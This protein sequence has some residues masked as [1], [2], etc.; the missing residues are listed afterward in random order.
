MINRATVGRPIYHQGA[1]SSSRTT[2][3]S[4]GPRQKA[5]VED[6]HYQRSLRLRGTGPETRDDDSTPKHFVK[7]VLSVKA[8]FVE[9][10]TDE[11]K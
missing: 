2:T 3:A 8:A 4:S 1:I 11:R 10:A 9:L 7:S 5:I 6:F